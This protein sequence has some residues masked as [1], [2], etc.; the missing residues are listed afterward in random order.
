MMIDYAHPHSKKIRDD[1]LKILEQSERAVLLKKELDRQVFSI[2]ILKSPM[3][4][5]LV[6]NEK[7]IYL[8]VPAPQDYADIEQ[9][10]D[11]AAGMVEL[12]F[13]REGQGRPTGNPDD[14]AYAQ[15]Q[16]LKNL[17]IMLHSF[18]IAEDLED[19]G[20]K[21]EECL[22]KIGLGKLYKAWK[23]GKDYQEFVDIY[24]NMLK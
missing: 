12:K 20:Y 17:E 11:L 10:L 4:Q 16:H 15:G 18:S 8:T 5:P 6:V 24:W 14:E 13:L 1:A 19:Q 9:V 3:E 23:D 21:A 7:E 22:R 2:Q